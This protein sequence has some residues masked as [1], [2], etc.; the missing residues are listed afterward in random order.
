MLHLFLYL[1]VALFIGLVV[2][3]YAL[4]LN[5]LFDRRLAETDLM[6]TEHNAMVNESVSFSSILNEFSNTEELRKGDPPSRE[7]VLRALSAAD[8]RRAGC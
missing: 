6:M 7:T 8:P 3:R 2:R 4:N 1:P 5:A